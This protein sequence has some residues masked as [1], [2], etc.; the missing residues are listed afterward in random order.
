[1]MEYY[2]ARYVPNNVTFIVVGDVDAEAVYRQLGDRYVFSDVHIVNLKG[3]GP[4][5][6]RFLIGKN[7]T[8]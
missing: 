8:A 3:K 6:A 2:Q 4:T 1:V 5:A 7:G